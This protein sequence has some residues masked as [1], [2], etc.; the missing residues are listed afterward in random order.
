LRA[1]QG[2]D[3][4][5]TLGSFVLFALEDGGLMTAGGGALLWANGKREATVLKNALEKFPKELLLTDMNAALAF[6]QLKEFERS[7]EKRKELHELFAQSIARS[8][9]AL[10]TRGDELP[11]SGFPV[12]VNGNVKEVIAYA[13]KKDVE[14]RPA[15]QGCVI[16]G[17]DMAMEKYPN[18]NSML[19]RCLAFPLH[20]RI[21]SQ[22]AQ[23]LTKVLASLP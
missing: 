13:R 1:V 18:A 9:H 10:A 14:T 21:D 16:D 5:G 23:R 17:D 19:L 7:R 8:P 4:A 11:Y 6:A 3:V 20:P 2:G 22:S 12:L 15:F